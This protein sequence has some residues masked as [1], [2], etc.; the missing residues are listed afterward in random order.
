MGT[1]WPSHRRVTEDRGDSS[2]TVACTSVVVG[3]RPQGLV[4]SSSATAARSLIS[5][6]ARPAARPRPFGWGRPGELDPG[7]GVALGEAVAGRRH[8]EAGLLSPSRRPPEGLTRSQVADGSAA[9]ESGSSPPLRT[10]RA[11]AAPPAPRSTPAGE[12]AS[13]AGAAGARVVDVE[14][15]GLVEVVGAT[16]VGGALVATEVAAPATI[17]PW[18]SVGLGARSHP[19]PTPVATATSSAAT[20]ATTLQ[21]RRVLPG[22]SGLPRPWRLPRCWGLWIPAAPAH[23]PRP[24][25]LPPGDPEPGSPEDPDPSPPDPDPP[26]S[27]MRSSTLPGGRRG[28]ASAGRRPGGPGGWRRCGGVRRRSRRCRRGG[29]PACG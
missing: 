2:V 18:S 29:R 19:S 1:D 26:V 24:G 11:T 22:P 6:D 20:S 3:A 12:T 9:Q 4:K 16:V 27:W 23:R 17:G 15:E 28:R 7:V 10:V 14:V 21:R 25:T 8:G 13:E 5:G